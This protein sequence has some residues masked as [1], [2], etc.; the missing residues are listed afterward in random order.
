MDLI[1]I[2]VGALLG[3]LIGTLAVIPAACRITKMQ[4]IMYRLEGQV[5]RRDLLIE[6][7]VLMAKE[8]KEDEHDDLVRVSRKRY[9]LGGRHSGIDPN[10]KRQAD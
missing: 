6:E 10:P 5:L 9:F 1:H 7:L 4:G 3:A 8:I 2:G